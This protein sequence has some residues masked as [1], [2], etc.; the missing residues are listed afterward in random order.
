METQKMTVHKALC[1][2]KTM[3]SRIQKAISSSPYVVANKHSSKKINGISIEEFCKQSKSAYQSANDLI[4][5]RNAIK[6]AIVLSNATTKVSINGTE[7]TV[8]E[9][10]EMK[11][12]GITHME[13]LVETLAQKYET[14]QRLAKEKNGDELDIRADDYIKDLFGSSDMKNAAE[15]IKKSRAE[16]VESQTY[17]LID[18]IGVQKEIDRLNEEITSFQTEVDSALSVSNA[19]TEIEFSY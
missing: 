4:N 3:D 7:Y 16:F 6:R 9:A 15:E 2:L 12:H 11:N 19:I 5:R 8:A 18:P 13:N 17:E 14:A 1:E 10:I